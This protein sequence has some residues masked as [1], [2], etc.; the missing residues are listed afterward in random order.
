MYWYK[1]VHGC[2]AFWVTKQNNIRGLADDSRWHF[3]FYAIRCK[4][5]KIITENLQV[6][7]RHRDIL[8]T[9]LSVIAI[10]LG[11]HF[12][13]SSVRVYGTVCRLASPRRRHWLPSGGVSNQSFSHM[14]W[15]GLCLILLCFVR[16]QSWLM[17]QSPPPSQKWPKMCRV[18]R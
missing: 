11:A 12:S 10:F 8:F 18:G 17:P 16:L 9:F 4:Y 7:V 15:R 13:T 3:S 2:Y 1:S 6:V 14:F 5:F